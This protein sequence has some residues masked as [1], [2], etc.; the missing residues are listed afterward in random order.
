SGCARCAFSLVLSLA[1]CAFIYRLNES[2]RRTPVVAS[3]LAAIVESSD[4]AIVGEDSNGA[5]TSWNRAAERLFG[6]TAAEAIGQPITFVIPTD[7]LSEEER[8]R[9]MIRGGRR[10]EPFETQRRRKD[11]TLADVSV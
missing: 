6:Y 11:G 4:D 3:R 9:T 1:V 8:R 5:V 10:V 2:L 7:R